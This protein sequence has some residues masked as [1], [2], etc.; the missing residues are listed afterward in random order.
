MS[1]IFIVKIGT[2]SLHDFESSPK[3]NKLVESIINKT[4]Q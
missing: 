1:D 4:R 3:V 2:E